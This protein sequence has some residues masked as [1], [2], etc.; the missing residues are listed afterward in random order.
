M[1][2]EY[3]KFKEERYKY[4]I[5]DKEKLSL[6]WSSLYY[7]GP[8]SGML[9]YQNDLYW[10]DCFDIINDDRNDYHFV[11]HELSKEEKRYELE[12]YYHFRRFYGKHNDMKIDDWYI[13]HWFLRLEVLPQNIETKEKYEEKFGEKDQEIDTFSFEYRRNKIIGR[14]IW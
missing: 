8:L 13:N 11:I 1:D 6:L 5:I 7:D 2:L 3:E 10:F 9:V 14:F 12:A 4:P